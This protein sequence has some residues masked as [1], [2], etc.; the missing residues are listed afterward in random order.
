MRY[1][2][3]T[4]RKAPGFTLMAVLVITLGIGANTAI[5]SVVH[6][7]LLQQL[8]FEDPQQL[9]SI[10]AKRTDGGQYPLSIPDFQD[11]QSQS[12]SIQQMAAFAFWGANLSGQGEPERIFEIR[13]SANFFQ[14]TG[15]S[16]FLGRTLLPDDDNPRSPHVMVMTYGLWQ[17]RF[18]GDRALI[19]QDL[20]L[21]GESYT[22]VG[23]LPPSFFFPM[24]A[25][26]MAV[27][28]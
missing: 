12:R 27:P 3:R 9:I 5:F 7:V 20:K 10:W 18:G 22:V 11:Y 8:P 23:V 21:N 26:D 15:T 17:R 14:V 16:A 25:A 1:G 2:L 19:G 13:T 6:A 4:L 28:L 24:R